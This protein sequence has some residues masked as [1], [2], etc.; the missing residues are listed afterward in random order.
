MDGYDYRACAI[1]SY[2]DTRLTRGH[3]VTEST[4]VHFICALQPCIPIME[5]IKNV[6][7]ILLASSEQHIIHKDHRELKPARQKRDASDLEN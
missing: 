3:G 2:E 7:G 6:A 4:L 5:M 1:E